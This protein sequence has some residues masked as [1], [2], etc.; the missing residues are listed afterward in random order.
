MLN[1]VPYQDLTINSILK[2]AET[3]NGKQKIV[4]VKPDGEIIHST[5]RELGKRV[6]KLSNA[7]TSLGIKSGDCVS[8]FAWN[9]INHLETYYAVPCMGAICHTVNPRL[10]RDQISYILRDAKSKLLIID[11]QFL[12]IVAPVIDQVP[13]LEGII[14]FG[15][16]LDNIP[17]KE[18]IA[19]D[20]YL[21]EELI[22]QFT[23]VFEWPKVDENTPSGCCY[24]SGTTGNPKGVLYSHRSTVLHSMAISMGDAMSIKSNDNILVVVPM[25]HVNAWGLPYSASMTGAT[26]VLPGKFMGDGEKL[27]ELI[28]TSDVNIAAGVPTVWQNW[29]SVMTKHKKRIEGELKIVIGGSA[30][31]ENL[32]VSLEELGCDVLPAWGMTETS[33]LG[34]INSCEEKLH[35]LSPGKP[36]YGVELRIVDDEGNPLPDNGEATGELQ[37]RGPWIARGYIGQPENTSY[38]NDGWFSTGDIAKIY[39]DGHMHIEDRA[40]DIIK[41]GGEW[42]SSTALEDVATSHPNVSSAAVISQPHPKW[43]ERPV[44]LVV[45]K[46]DSQIDKDE[47]LQWYDG[48][49]ASWWRPDDIHVIDTLPLTATGKIDK[50]QLR[51]A[52]NA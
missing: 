18:K 23:E 37:I 20:V 42:I 17:G 38:S 46:G 40:K 24:T 47:L 19:I 22:N 31:T 50:K 44:L 16:T 43:D 25:F 27:S 51:A 1:L 10:H 48:K 11:P 41:S 3:I 32:R 21:Y 2:H 7:L 52:F 29:V 33:P 45:P 12:P 6:R 34:C 15:D 30:C 39:P 26:L 28:E 4:S 49:V 5:Y 9:D 36:P 8:T 13:S 35:R 14:I